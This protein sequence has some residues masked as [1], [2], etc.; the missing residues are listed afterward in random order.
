V[1]LQPLAFQHYWLSHPPHREPRPE[2][3]TSLGC[4]RPA[5]A[6]ALQVAGVSRSSTGAVRLVWPASSADDALNA[7]SNDG[8]YGGALGVNTVQ[9]GRVR[10]ARRV[11]RLSSPLTPLLHPNQLV[12]AVQCHKRCYWLWVLPEVRP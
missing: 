9:V 8:F 7:R 12:A 3:D 1:T 6:R 4:R 10:V 11:S 5:P 2:S